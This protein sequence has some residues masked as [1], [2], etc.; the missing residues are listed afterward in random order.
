MSTRSLFTL[1]C[2]ISGKP[3]QIARPLQNH[4]YFF[5]IFNRNEKTRASSNQMFKAVCIFFILS[6]SNQVHILMRSSFEKREELG[7]S[8]WIAAE[9][10]WDFD[11]SVPVCNFTHCFTLSFPSYSPHICLNHLSLLVCSDSFSNRAFYIIKKR[12]ILRRATAS[13]NTR[14]Q[15]NVGLMLVSFGWRWANINQTLDQHL[16]LA[17]N[18]IAQ[19]LFLF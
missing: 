10:E 1:I 13:A 6:T 2:V 11:K 19:S 12:V 14:L 5:P 18:Q 9:D 8:M 16:L 3:C 4:Y 15:P 7:M 17:G